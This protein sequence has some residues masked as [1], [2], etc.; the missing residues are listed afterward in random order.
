METYT[1]QRDNDRKLKFDGKEI[2]SVASEPDKSQGRRYL[3]EQT[4]LSL[5]KKKAGAFVCG[6]VSRV[7][8]DDERDIHEGA[9]SNSVE[10]VI[11]FFGTDWLAKELCAQAGIEA[12]EVIS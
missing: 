12:V 9:V 5:Y 3:N 6:R 8:L 7:T 10:A 2:A 4:E 11:A 1:I